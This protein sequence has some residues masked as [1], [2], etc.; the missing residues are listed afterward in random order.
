M[1]ATDA[2]AVGEGYS[3]HSVGQMGSQQQRQRQ[4]MQASAGASSVRG[5]V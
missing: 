4:A 3:C 5:S 1:V 2:H